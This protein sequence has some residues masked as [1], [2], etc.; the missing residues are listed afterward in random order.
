MLLGAD[1]RHIEPSQA[2]ML[3]TARRATEIAARLSGIGR[4]S[5]RE[6]ASGARPDAGRILKNGEPEAARVALLR[7]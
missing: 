1:R 5:G 6:L 3:A 2:S 7:W 4:R